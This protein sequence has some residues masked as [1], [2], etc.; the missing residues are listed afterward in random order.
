[1]STTLKPDFQSFML[2]TG[3]N[4]TGLK[5]GHEDMTSEN[6]V[7]TGLLD[8]SG[9]T[10]SFARDMELAVGEIIKS[11]RDSSR[12]EHIMYRHCHFGTGFREHHGYTPLSKLN[13]GDYDGCYQPGGA[14]HLY[15][16]CVNVIEATQVYG[17]EITNKKYLCNGFIYIITDGADY[18]STLTIPD[19]RDALAKA[20]ASEDLES[21][22]TVLIGVNV[23]SY[24]AG[25][26]KFKNDAGLTQFITLENTSAKALAKLS[27]FIV[28]SMMAQS[29]HLGLGGPS[30]PLD[31]NT[32]KPVAA[33]STGSLTF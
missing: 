25:L 15:D 14:T 17:E 6:T 19:V 9:S 28:S 2:P 27:G 22:M 30:Q 5:I 13:P 11:L 12:A 33:G 26:E 32:G 4:F 18:G 8:E 23:G 31:P 24:K 10:N 16:S 20:I 29:Q 3:G 21:L 7:A 1:M